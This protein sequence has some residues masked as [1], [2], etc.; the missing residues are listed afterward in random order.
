[1]ADNDPVV[2]N[3]SVDASALRRELSEAERLSRSF[4][5]ALGDALEAG[6]VRG[7]SLGD[8]LRGLGSRLSEIALSAALKPVETAFGSIF[9]KLTTGAL[10]GLSP[11]G[12]GGGLAAPAPLASVGASLASAS[13]PAAPSVPAP[14]PPTGPIT[15]NIATPDAESFRRSEAQV[16]AALAR[17]VARGRR[18]L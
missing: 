7:R 16:S 6:V 5:G 4:G 18:G 17:A 1:M 8:V 9:S 14:S 12:A 2:V 15:V 10:G 13:A 11:F 3:V